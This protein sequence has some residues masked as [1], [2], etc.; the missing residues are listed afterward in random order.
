MSDMAKWRV[1]YMGRN[2]CSISTAG[3]ELL[4][5][6]S[7]EEDP[8]G[9][10]GQQVTVS[11]QCALWPKRPMGSWGALQRVASRA[12]EL[13]PTPP[14]PVILCLGCCLLPWF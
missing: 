8:G 13:L 9:P 14:T 5:R 1:L 3:A 11:Q 4:Q 6:S 12:R 10:G 7:A 2:N